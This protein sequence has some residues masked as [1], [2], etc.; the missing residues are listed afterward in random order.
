M[1]EPDEIIRTC[2]DSWSNEQEQFA[3]HMAETLAALEGYQ[4]SLEEWQLDLTEKA[5]AIVEQ[6]QR[7]EADRQL[8][9]KQQA[10]DVAMTAELDQVR[11][12]VDELRQKL[13]TQVVPAGARVA[14]ETIK[15]MDPTV[16]AKCQ[17]ATETLELSMNSVAKQFHKLRQQQAARRS[18][19][20]A[21]ESSN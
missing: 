10:T 11:A 5:A 18:S 12:E 2:V 20:R 13:T 14:A 15:V 21:G 8:F 17:A 4:K 6:E 1:P 16:P 3:A 9:I 7:I 19:P